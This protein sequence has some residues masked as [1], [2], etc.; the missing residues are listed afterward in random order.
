MSFAYK[1]LNPAE[2]KSV[3]YVA[4][5][6]YEYD[7]SSYADNNI[8]TYIGEY[9]PITVDQ[10]FDPQND[11]L[12]TDQQYRRLI[13]ESIRHLYYQ[14]YVTKSSQDQDVGDDTLIYPENTNYFWHSSSYDNYIQNT[15]NSGSFSNFKSFPYFEKVEND[16]DGTAAYGSAL[17]FV[18]NAAKIRVI[19]IPK[20]IYGEG[21]KPYTFELSGSEFFIADDGQGNLFDYV[22]LTSE[23]NAAEYSNPISKYAGDANSLAVPVGNIFYNHGI[24]VITNQDY[25][26]FIEGSPVARNDYPEILNVSTEKTL[27]ILETDFD[28]CSQINTS[29]VKTFT[30]PGYTFPDFSVS[31]SGDIVITPNINS[32]SPGGYG[33]YYSVENTLGLVSNTGSIILTLTSDPLTSSIN[34]ITQSCYQNTGNVSAS[35]TFSIDKGVPPY[36]WSIDNTNYTPV[37]DLFQP[38]VSASIY[39]SRSVVLSIVDVD[40]TLVTN[41]I[42]TAFLPISA[43]LFQDDVSHCGTADGTIYASASGDLPIT[44]SLSASFLNSVELPN[45]LSNLEVGTYTVYLKD[46]N[47]CTTTSLIEVTKTTYVTA[48]YL[49]KH[50]DCYGSSTGDIYLD[51]FDS[52]GEERDQDLYLTGGT[53]P[54]EYDWTGPNG[55]NTSSDY[56]Y[57]VP[58]G[59]YLLNIEDADGCFYGFTFDITSSEQML[60][61]ASIDYTSS[62]FTSS[63]LVSNLTGGI[64]P[65]NL[66]ASTNL[67]EYTLFVTASGTFSIPLEADELNSGSCS[68]FIQDFLTCSA[69]TESVEIFG[70]TWQLTGSNC[71]DGT[72]SLTG[73]D[74]GQRNLNFYN[75]PSGS[76]YVTVLIHSGSETPIQI[77]TSGSATGSFVWNFNDTLYIDVNTGSNDNFYLRREFSGSRYDETGPANI[78]GSEVTNSAIILGNANITNFNENIDVSL[79]FGTSHSISSLHLTASKVNS[80]NLPTNINFKFTKQ[81]NLDDIRDNFTASAN[82]LSLT[83]SGGTAIADGSGSNFI[84]RNDEFTDII[85]GNSGSFIGPNTLLFRDSYAFGNVLNTISGSN[86]EYTDGD[87]WSGSVSA[88]YFGGENA[89]YFTQRT[90]KVWMLAADIDNIGFLDVYSYTEEGFYNSDPI[91]VRQNTT[92]SYR[93]YNIYAASQRMEHDLM[94]LMIIPEDEFSQLNFPQGIGSGEVFNRKLEVINDVNR[95]YYLFMSPIGTSGSQAQLDNRAIAVGKRF[96]DYVIYG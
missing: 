88:S 72:G 43:A 50:I 31:G 59:T 87:I 84:A 89:Q 67:S 21:V 62:A 41:S 70:R 60:Y 11:N 92:S 66:T 61:T 7:S 30:Y 77:V 27:N 3:P 6:Q 28:D 9:I 53:E 55:F 39:P 5:K 24:A 49:I 16:Y 75:T 81:Y 23:Y 56:I 34:S 22:A 33:L 29:S 40:G 18:E 4:N 58:S 2:I 54:F 38:V 68:V 32:V 80:E 35:V 57:N 25:L 37:N 78:T 90:D 86:I 44:A 51:T 13:F 36:S 19:S 17:Y 45:T 47:N 64:F 52:D 95:V 73:K 42:D 69:A 82:F 8:Q 48:S 74:V 71:E 26:C 76:E 20:N 91:G 93:D 85:Y 63:L 1:K 79:T 14:N 94:Y 96:I 15:M 10:P 65:Y 83:G 46:A 12:T